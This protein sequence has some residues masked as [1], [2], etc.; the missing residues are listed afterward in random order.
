VPREAI[1]Q[2]GYIQDLTFEDVETG[3]REY[4]ELCNAFPRRGLGV[5]VHFRDVG[6]EDP[7]TCE[8]AKVEGA[9]LTEENAQLSAALAAAK[10]RLA[11]C[12]CGCGDCEPPA[13][14]PR[15]HLV[16][17]DSE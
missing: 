14:I 12:S 16:G 5:D 8:A 4:R 15:A 7:S 2:C 6:L 9:K 13:K 1:G 17:H 10:K 3:L 11:L